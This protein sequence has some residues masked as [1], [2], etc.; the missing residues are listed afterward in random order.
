VS[1]GLADVRLR[2][3]VDL[4]GAC[5]E[6]VSFSSSPWERSGTVREGVVEST[7][8]RSISLLNESKAK[9]TKL[10]SDFVNKWFLPRFDQC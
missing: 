10:E 5:V 9:L 8:K 1:F 3:T 7:L 2:L 4:V 6:A